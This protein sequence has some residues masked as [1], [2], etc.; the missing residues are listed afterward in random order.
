[1]TNLFVI[2]VAL[3]IFFLVFLLARRWGLTFR[4]IPSYAGLGALV[5]MVAA[6]GVLE[7][8]CR[9]YLLLR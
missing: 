6:I 8:Q 7:L 5:G 9:D 2:V 4:R 1:M 3:L